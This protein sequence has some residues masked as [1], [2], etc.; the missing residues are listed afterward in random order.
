MTVITMLPTGLTAAQGPQA[1]VRWALRNY[2][3]QAG[4]PF[5]LPAQ[6]SVV[7][8]PFPGEWVICTDEGVTKVWLGFVC[9]PLTP[10]AAE[11]AAG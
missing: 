10:R 8:R 3:D 6:I 11:E 4:R 9:V 1:A 5:P 7:A 2:C